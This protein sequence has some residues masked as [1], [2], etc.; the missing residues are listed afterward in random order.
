MILIGISDL[1]HL[2]DTLLFYKMGKESLLKIII[3][4][5]LYY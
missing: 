3:L 1:G 2:I 4:R 5:L